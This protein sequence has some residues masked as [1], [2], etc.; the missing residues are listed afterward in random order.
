MVRGRMLRVIKYLDRKESATYKEIAKALG[1]TERAIRYDI[2]R[3]ND[4]L[5]VKKL[6][7][8]QKLPKG[9]LKFPQELDLSMIM[10]ESE[11]VFSRKERISIL[12]FMIL[13]DTEKLNI[14][15]LSQELQ[16][17][18]RSIQNDMERIQNDLQLYGMTLEY[19]KK[20]ELKEEALAAY[21]V[22]SSELKKYVNLIL[23]NDS[24]NE[25]EK[26]MQSLFHQVFRPI[27]LDGILEWIDT[28]IEK[29]NWIFSD[30][31]FR[32]YVA[33][34]LNFTW[35]LLKG[36][37]LPEKEWVRERE[38]GN[39]IFQYGT[40]LGKNLSEREMQILAGFSRYTN[41]YV[42]LDAIEELPNIEDMA[43]KLVEKMQSALQIDFFQDGILMKGLMN[44]F[45]PM[46]ERMKSHL[47]LNENVDSFVPKEYQYVY[48]ALNHILRKD[49][50]LRNLTEN[51]RVYI[52]V[53]FIGSLR[54]MQKNSY[55]NVLLICG[56]GYGT[57]SVVKD[58][59]L[60]QYQVFV[61]QSISAYQ[62]KQF[63]DWDEID[64]VVSTVKIDLPTEKPMVQ[65]KV[66]FDEEDYMKL[67][68]LGLQ[69]KN[70]LTDYFAIERRLGFLK[71]EEKEKVMKIIKEELG[72]EEVKVP[73]V[74]RGLSDLMGEEDIRCVDSVDHWKQAVSC[75][76]EILKQHGNDGDLYYQSM[77]DTMEARGFYAVTD[78]MFALLHGSETAGIYVSGMSLLISRKPVE[79]GEKK[80]NLIFCLASRDKK[81]HIPVVTKM[82][83]MITR[84]N[85]IEDLKQCRNSAQAMRIIIRCE[86]EVEEC[87]QS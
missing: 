68:L 31:S 73:A 82:M 64:A 85:F 32:W 6:P 1:E 14:R 52:A 43:R 53:F 9:L 24:M 44:H 57:T 76:T 51:E 59:L 40:I 67:D 29:S 79:F 75:C 18:R 3:M 50:L 66:I 5:S 83:R 77:I 45:G 21:D 16:V 28:M 26:Y 71:D 49:S 81:E 33:N 35:Y 37:E 62:V 22:R 70:T 10:G 60:N 78:R 58:A 55:M 23:R 56:F 30:E 42:N 19:E 15:K 2:D 72:Y 34:V 54:R 86:K 4:E 80:V 25:Y 17:T 36:K 38:I 74:Y 13:F 7:L 46:I 65:V 27:D 61:K 20:F 84:T 47:Q 69:K 87:S 63:Q 39:S 8:I 48:D 12:R 11:F 41:K